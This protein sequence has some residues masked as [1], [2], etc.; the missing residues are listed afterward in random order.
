MDQ[1]VWNRPIAQ[2]CNGVVYSARLLDGKPEEYPLAVKMMFNYDAESNASSILRA[3]FRETVPARTYYHNPEL[4]HWEKGL[5]EDKKTLPPHRNIVQMY[6]VFTDRVPKLP[7]GQQLYPD[8]LPPRIHATGSGRNMSLFLVMKRYDCSLTEYIRDKQPNVRCSSLLLAQLL[9][10][11]AHMS[12]H[13]IAHRDLKSDNILVDLSEGDTNP[14]LVVTDFGCCLADKTHGLVV[15]Y[16]SAD[17]D[18]G[19]NRALMAPEIASARP[20]PFTSLNYSKADLWAVG[21]IAYQLFGLVNPFYKDLNSVTFNDDQLPELPETVPSLIK[22]L[23]SN[24]LSKTPS[25][26]R[27]SPFEIKHFYIFFSAT[28]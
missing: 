6:S 26:V 1:I 27:Q 12:I 20:G 28:K 22:R 18:R 25:N 17:T 8:A 10:A 23:I 2:G 24:I 21:T 7:E 19:G 13:G 15:P 14:M 9:E 11:V 4:S 3:M 16:H 5:V